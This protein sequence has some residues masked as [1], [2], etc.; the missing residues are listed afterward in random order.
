MG[1]HYADTTLQ[2]AREGARTAADTAAGV[3]RS[4]Y[5]VGRRGALT[6]S[7][8]AAATAGPCR[9]GALLIPPDKPRGLS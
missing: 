2:T 6:L 9:P 7:L 1:R 4:A 5:E 3:A 8:R